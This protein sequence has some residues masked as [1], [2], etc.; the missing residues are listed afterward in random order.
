[1][2]CDKEKELMQSAEWFLDTLAQRCLKKSKRI[3]PALQFPVFK[4]FLACRVQRELQY[5][6]SYCDLASVLVEV[7]SNIS[8]HDLDELMEDS[9]VLDR[10]LARDL[11]FLPLRIHFDYDRILPLRR[12]RAKK[13]TSLFVRL[14]SANRA[15][16]YYDMLRKTLN[17]KEFLELYN[18]L[19]VL[20]ADETFIIN[21]SL[22]SIIDVNSKKL[23]ERIYRSILDIGIEMNREMADIIYDAECHRT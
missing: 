12:E 8:E 5:Y 23:A 6:R 3:V 16:D 18:E 9:F 13:Q 22:K 1:M 14:L 15:R 20:Y 4:K 2:A 7:E 21:S 19:V 11:V 17:K 10:C